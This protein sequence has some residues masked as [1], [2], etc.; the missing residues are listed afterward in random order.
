MTAHPDAPRTDAIQQRLAHYSHTLSYDIL[1][2]QAI[3][4]AKALIADTTGVLVGGFNCEPC[5]KLR[6]LA[7]A[8]GSS[9]GATIIGTRR[10]T[11]LDGA[12]FVNA[13]TARY[14]EANDVYA[15]FKPGTSHGHPSDVIMPLLGVA[16]HEHASG[17][18]FLTAV[19]LAYEIFQR[20]CDACH[21]KGF[22]AATF[23]CIAI[24]AA[25]GKLLRLSEQQIAHAISMAA[26]TCNILKQVRANHV[27]VWKALA[28]GQA[29]R[30]GVHAALLAQA[31]LEGPN[32]P[33]VGT[34]GWCDHVAGLRF[35]LTEMGGVGTGFLICES[36]IKTR[37][38]RALT[39]S[40]I[41][42]AEKLASK[43]GDLGKVSRILVATYQRAKRGTGPQ[44]W[45]PDNRE[46]ADHSIP[47]C[48]AAALIDGTVTAYSFDEQHLRDP[49]L[50]QLMAKVEIVEDEEFTSAY[51]ALPQT[52]RSRVSVYTAG[53]ECFEAEAGGDEDDL[54]ANK[55][56]AW[57]ERKFRAMAEDALGAQRCG[58]LL[59][60]IWALEKC[61]D[62]GSVVAALALD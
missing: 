18:E 23:G 33:F 12:A 39:I 2:N 58:A 3:H 27:T 16:E 28:S 38:A 19:V 25:T 4:S 37:P 52:H 9:D 6:D 47:Y 34:S 29:G 10:R 60:T 42:A 41:L 8:S 48:V 55:S 32:L 35:E 46:T 62:V 26:S 1:S 15:R 24:A 22:D 31:G 40:S 51:K 36:R 59:S 20:L 49:Q 17:R 5:V 54:A 13:S 43:A 53:G 56:D 45:A 11:T 61:T 30:E 44:H 50:R 7:A 14:L 57:I 21:S